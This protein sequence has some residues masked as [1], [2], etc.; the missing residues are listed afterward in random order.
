LGDFAA[1]GGTD[2]ELFRCKTIAYYIF[3]TLRIEDIVSNTLIAGREQLFFSQKINFPIITTGNE[4]ENTV[5][6]SKKIDAREL[7]NYTRDV[8][9]NTN[10]IIQGMCF[11]DSKIKVSEEKK[12]E[13]IKTKTVSEDENAFW[14][15][16]YWCKKTYGGLLLMPFSR[17]HLMHFDACFRILAALRK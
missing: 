11:E 3:H 2:F 16:D 4:I 1:T 9:K 10:E 7:K 17:H 13:L 14:L 6:L 8:L 5:E 12:A 15:V